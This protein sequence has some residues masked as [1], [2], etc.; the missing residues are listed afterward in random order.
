MVRLTV[1]RPGSFFSSRISDGLNL[2]KA[3]EINRYFKGKAKVAFG[4]GTDWSGPQGIEAL[5]IVCKVAIVNGLDVAKLS[6]AP[7]KNMCR[8]PEAIERLHREIEW[9]MKNDK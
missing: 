4:I 3:T 2:K 7:G 8:N 9:R 6:D 1:S 5:N